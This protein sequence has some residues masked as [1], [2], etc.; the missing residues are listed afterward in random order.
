MR[1]VNIAIARDEVSIGIIL[2]HS[3]LTQ[4]APR[5]QLKYKN[6]LTC[7]RVTLQEESMTV[8]WLIS[9]DAA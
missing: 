4:M 5:I 6:R 2:S 7:Y 8:R 3:L 9:W 1:A